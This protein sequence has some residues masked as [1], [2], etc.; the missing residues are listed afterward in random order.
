MSEKELVAA[1]RAANPRSRAVS[2]LK[3]ERNGSRTKQMS[4]ILCGA[5]GPTWCAGY[6][7][8]VQARKWEKAHKAVHC[9]LPQKGE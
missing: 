4:C 6:R 1:Y 2:I 9:S 3:Y 5:V 8:T 7:Q